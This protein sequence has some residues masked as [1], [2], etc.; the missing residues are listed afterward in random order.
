MNR[1]LLKQQTATV[2]VEL[3]HVFAAN[4]YVM[5]GKSTYVFRKQYA[6]SRL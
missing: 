1:N 4:Q 2:K 3:L 6:K 5:V